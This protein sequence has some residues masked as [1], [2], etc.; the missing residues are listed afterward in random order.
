MDVQ[1]SGEIV[2]EG[3]HALHIAG[4][5]REGRCQNR[6]IRGRST[7]ATLMP[8][9]T[10]DAA[11]AF[12]DV[13]EALRQAVAGLAETRVPGP[14]AL[15]S[16]LLQGLTGLGQNVLLLGLTRCHRGGRPRRRPQQSSG[17]R[18]AAF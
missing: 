12:K 15:M 16:C 17:H 8:Q 5:P 10:L 6:A 2:R 9:P 11:Q 1:F 14:S 7:R 4:Q 3:G 13:G 18:D